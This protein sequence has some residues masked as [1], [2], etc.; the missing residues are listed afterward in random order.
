MRCM[1]YPVITICIIEMDKKKPWKK[2]SIFFK[3][4]Q[5][6]SSR[7]QQEWAFSLEGQTWSAHLWIIFTLNF[8]LM[9]KPW[10]FPFNSSNSHILLQKQFHSL[11]SLRAG[12]VPQ[13]PEH[14]QQQE[15]PYGKEQMPFQ[16]SFAKTS[17]KATGKSCQEVAS[18]SMAVPLTHR[19]CQ[20]H[21]SGEVPI[22]QSIV[23][24]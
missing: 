18:S 21:F 12:S 14:S 22:S 23:L 11:C 16:S 7:Q 2:L 15:H 8:V 24:D 9:N 20:V 5:I 4:S 1:D 13:D 17:W 3:A 10:P 19:I 6:M